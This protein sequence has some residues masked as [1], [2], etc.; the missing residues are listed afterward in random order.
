MKSFLNHKT[1]VVSFFILAFLI[2]IYKYVTIKGQSLLLIERFFPM[3]GWIEIFILAIYGGFLFNQ[4]IKQQTKFRTLAWS[5]FSIVFFAQ[6][7]LG[8][9]I[10]QRFLMTGKLHLPVPAIIIGGPVLRGEIGFMPILF[11]STVLISGPAWCSQLCYFGAIDNFMAHGKR[12][13]N[14]QLIWNLKF[15]FF[16]LFILAVIILRLLKVSNLMATILG[17]AFGLIGLIISFYF[18]SKKKTMMHCS[19]WCPIN[20]LVNTFSF[21]YPIKIRINNSCDKCMVCTNHCKYLALTQKSI[22][23]HKT[24][25]SCTLCGECLTSCH[26]SALEYRFFKYKGEKV[27]IFWIGLTVV[28]HVIFLTL[29]R[30]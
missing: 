9:L 1:F 25:I 24:T 4:M 5:V 16:V 13:N 8:I 15:S 18:S 3:S 12:K 17:I 22:F 7:F 30:I 6:L 21:I 27:R 19:Y 14:I 11:L 28:I 23:K 10:D 2:P 20:Y 29:A 26:K